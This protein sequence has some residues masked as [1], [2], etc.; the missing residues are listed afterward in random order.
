MIIACGSAPRPHGP[1]AR[2][3]HRAPSGA[4]RAR[5]GVHQRGAQG[6]RQLR[7]CSSAARSAVA[8]LLA[9]VARTPACA[10]RR[11]GSSGRPCPA[12]GR[13]RGRG[14][15]RCAKS[16][17]RRSAEK[18]SSAKPTESNTVT[19]ARRR[20]ARRHAR[21]HAPELGDRRSRP[22]SAGCRPRC[23][24]CGSYSTNT[25]ARAQHVGVQLGLARAVAADAVDV[26]AGLEHRRA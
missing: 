2:D 18:S 11:T 19:S 14:R 23:G 16:R 20:A 12:P 10:A 1:A 3:C 7:R 5:A 26:H 22:A 21:E 24:V 9:A 4:S 25:A 6:L 15:A 17:S 8:A 13:S